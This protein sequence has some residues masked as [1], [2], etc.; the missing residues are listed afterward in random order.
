MAWRIGVDI[1]GTFTDVA[2]VEEESGCIGVAKVPT[3]PE[4]LAAGVLGALTSAMRRYD[5]GALRRRP[6]VAR[7]HRGDQCHPG[8][9]TRARRADYHEGLPRPAGAAAPGPGRSLLP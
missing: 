8:G 3:T 1:G 7:H 2:L 5:V 9:K 6:A 4:D